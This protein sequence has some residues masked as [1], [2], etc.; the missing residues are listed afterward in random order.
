MLLIHAERNTDNITIPYKDWEIV[1]SKL[2][3]IEEVK[4]IL[5]KEE[6]I[7]KLLGLGK[8]IWEDI[9]PVEYQRHERQNW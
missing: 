7:Q 8:E 3:Q 6:K 5:T 9:D 2:K 4:V 1:L